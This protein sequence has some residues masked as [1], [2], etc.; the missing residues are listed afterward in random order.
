M[1]ETASI[2]NN[3]IHHLQSSEMRELTIDELLFVAGGQDIDPDNA[4]GGGGG[5]VVSSVAGIVYA[6]SYGAVV[7]GVAGALVGAYNGLNPAATG[8]GGMITGGVSGALNHVK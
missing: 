8:L 2:S 7:G 6:A 1:I 4:G 3:S 5:S